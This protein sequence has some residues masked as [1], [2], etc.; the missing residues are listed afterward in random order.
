MLYKQWGLGKEVYQDFHALIYNLDW[1]TRKILGQN[2]SVIDVCDVN[3]HN[4]ACISQNQLH[5]LYTQNK[6]IE[7]EYVFMP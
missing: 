2:D 1:F 5:T 3:M 4:N 7:F 6:H